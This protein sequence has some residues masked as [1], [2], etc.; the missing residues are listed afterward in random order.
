M[1]RFTGNSVKSLI[2]RIRLTVNWV[3]SVLFLFV[4]LFFWVD[5]L[6]PRSTAE[7]MSGDD[8]LAYPHYSWASLPE[9]GNHYFAH[10]LSPLTDN[11]SF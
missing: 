4:C 11:C 10:I 2:P 9:A 7:V 1:I 8:Q 6:R 5:A 3:E